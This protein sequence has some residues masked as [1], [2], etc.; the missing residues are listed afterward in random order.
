MVSARGHRRSVRTAC[1]QARIQMDEQE[2]GTGRCFVEGQCEQASAS[3]CRVV[4]DLDYGATGRDLKGRGII[5]IC[6]AMFSCYLRTCHCTPS[7]CR[8]QRPST[9]GLSNSPTPQGSSS[10]R[11]CRSCS[12]KEDSILLRGWSPAYLVGICQ[13]QPCCFAQPAYSCQPAADAKN[14][15]DMTINLVPAV[16]REGGRQV[17]PSWS[18]SAL[19]RL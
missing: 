11:G 2:Y 1:R 14:I 5:D 6:R 8:L 7:A 3:P 12:E 15:V 4:L 9:V 16:S 10:L 13:C 18:L 19:T 17:C